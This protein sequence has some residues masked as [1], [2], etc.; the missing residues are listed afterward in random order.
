M[1]K[2][3]FLCMFAM[4]AT[5]SAQHPSLDHKCLMNKHIKVA[6]IPWRPFFIIHCNEKEIQDPDQCPDKATMKY[7]GVLWEFLKLVKLA[8]N[9]TFTIFTPPDRKWGFCNGKNNCTG[10]IGMV[11]RRKVDFALG[12][13]MQYFCEIE[14][15]SHI[16]ILGPFTP[17]LNRAQ[18]VKF[19]NPIGIMAAYTIIVPLRL[20]DNLMSI[21]E[22]LSFEVWICLLIS[23]PI[24]IGSIIIMNFLYIGSTNWEVVVSSVIRGVLSERKNRLP[25]KHVYQKLLVLVWSWMMVVLISAYKGNLLALITKP[26]VHI[27]FTNA[28]GMVEQNQMEWAITGD[29]LFSPYAKRHPKGT[30]I[31]KIYDLGV[32]SS[33]E[34]SAVESK[35]YA[36]ICDVSSALSVA[37]KDFSKTGTCSYYMTDDNILATDSALAFQVCKVKV[38]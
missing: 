32:Q 21:T 28:K 24:Y 29:G 25:P 12:R 11:N 14:I 8:R 9:V 23:I 4:E 20:Q 15:T 10:M 22:P 16:K 34:C 36:V 2:I 7:S 33:S 1:L 6:A 37:A 17:T 3:C 27:P 38:S 26:T 35:N 5:L 18:A 31:R 30:L 19:S 13:L